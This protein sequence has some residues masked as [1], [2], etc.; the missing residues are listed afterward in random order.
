MASSVTE[1]SWQRVA[2]LRADVRTVL[3]L[4][5]YR[6]LFAAY[7]L[8]QLAWSIGTLALA[9][10]VYRRTDSAVGAAAFF[11]C[12]QFLPALVSPP[13]VARLDQRAARRVL[14]VLYAIEALA[15]AGLAAL[16]DDF[17]LAPLLA[18]TLLDGA[19]ALAARSI[20]RACT[21]AVTSP[22]GLLRE[23]NA[24]A[25]AASSICF[26]LGPALGAVIADTA[27][28][29]AALL[30]CAGMF[31]LITLTLATATG[32][33]TALPERERS[34]GR[35][36]A[37]LRYTAE[38]PPIRA[39]LG[40]QAAALVFFTVSIPVEVVLAEKTLHSGRGGYAALLSSWGI[41]TV[42]GS[43]AY[44]HWRSRPGRVLVALS[45]ASI[46]VGFALMAAAP[47]LAVAIV[48]AVLGG[49]G[50]GV[51][52]VAARTL[53]QEEVNQRWM[54]LIMSLNESLSEAV[55]G[56]GILI[57]GAITAL[58]SPRV[59]LAV[60]A[61][62]ALAVAVAA[63][64]VLGPAGVSPRPGQPPGPGE[65]AGPGDAPDPARAPG[66]APPAAESAVA[67]N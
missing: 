36:R 11:I 34:R 13:L 30:A 57:G 18:L 21:V 35:L 4:P 49:V 59:A 42:L 41:G 63:W 66:E 3:K 40:I 62:G 29:S 6:R 25:N 24:L 48:G 50:N 5:A 44:A 53:L 51:E 27:G 17:S 14:P 64:L 65:P 16:A 22:V 28:T 15:F 45:S 2:D 12:A 38:R 58:S 31:A 56:A 10:L 60:A 39:L 8:T 20:A 43:A 7:T 26:M 61:A 1:R 23:G 32:L 19:V 9:V 55:P 52:A 37:A 47:S 67:A 54:T 46:G 33:P